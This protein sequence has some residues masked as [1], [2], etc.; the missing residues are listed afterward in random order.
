M[1]RGCDSPDM[2]YC[3]LLKF[4]VTREGIPETLGGT[5]SLLCQA[6]AASAALV[7]GRDGIPAEVL[8][9][10]LRP[11][12]AHGYTWDQGTVGIE[13]APTEAMNAAHHYTPAPGKCHHRNCAKDA[14]VKPVVMIPILNRPEGMGYMEGPGFCEDH[15]GIR[16]NLQT[17][18]AGAL[19]VAL[20]QLTNAG[21]N[22]DKANMTVE[23]RLLEWTGPVMITPDLGAAMRE[24]LD[25][26]RQLDLHYRRAKNAPNN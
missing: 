21:L 5:I 2:D 11:M 8:Q 7:W 9:W 6:C 15:I 24:E 3:V 16:L 23:P 17:V 14:T 10:L 26:K 1:C 22:P 19:R 13:V 4:R 25:R 18:D 12:E 20:M